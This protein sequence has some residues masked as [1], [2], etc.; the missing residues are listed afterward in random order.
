MLRG[1]DHVEVHFGIGGHGDNGFFV[2][3]CGRVVRPFQGRERCGM[4]PTLCDPSGVVAGDDVFQRCATLSGSWVAV[5]LQRY[6][7]HSGPKMVRVA[8]KLARCFSGS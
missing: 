8:R 7:I 3:V 1:K 2:K 4:F 5:S 6:A